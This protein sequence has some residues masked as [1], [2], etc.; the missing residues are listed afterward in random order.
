MPVQ[1]VPTVGAVQEFYRTNTLNE[2]QSDVTYALNDA[3]VYEGI[4][5]RSVQNSNLNNS[6][7]VGGEVNETWWEIVGGGKGSTIIEN[8]SN[9]SISLHNVIALSDDGYAIIADKQ[10]LSK[11]RVLGIAVEDYTINTSYVNSSGVINEESYTSPSLPALVLPFHTKE[12]YIRIG[13]NNY[14]LTS[15][16]VDSISPYSETRNTDFLDVGSEVIDFELT[17]DDK[18]LIIKVSDNTVRIYNE[19][20]EGSGIYDNFTDSLSIIPD[21]ILVSDYANDFVIIRG[22]RLFSYYTINSDGT[23]TQIGSEINIDTDTGGFDPYDDTVYIDEFQRV[24]FHGTDGGSTPYQ[25]FIYEYHNGSWTN[26]FSYYD[27]NFTLPTEWT[28]INSELVFGYLGEGK[29]G[30]YDRI[31]EDFYLYNYDATN[32]TFSLLSSLSNISSFFAH[33]FKY[34]RFSEKRNL[35]VARDKI[36]SVDGDTLRVTENFNSEIDGFLRSVGFSNEFLY[37]MEEP[38]EDNYTI[39]LYKDTTSGLEIQKIGQLAD[40]YTLATITPGSDLFLGN[41][42][43]IITDTNDIAEGEARVFLGTMGRNNIIDLLIMEPDIND[44]D[45]ATKDGVPVGGI[46]PLING[47]LP[48]DGYVEI[49]AGTQLAVADYPTLAA[50]HPD[51]LDGTGTLI[52]IPDPNEGIRRTDFPSNP[53]IGWEVW[54]TDLEAWFKYNGEFWLEI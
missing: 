43:A 24:F 19:T 22:V 48:A 13:T 37:V 34:N 47:Q 26:R 31:N 45:P 36:I 54:R 50:L 9:Q 49:E 29:V 23:L 42:G 1:N 44:Y 39:T 46:L 16:L 40:P 27:T 18:F 7:V 4:P 3:I 25:P 14:R 53:D 30:L 15:V 32:F 51:W 35:F 12:G 10:D 28:T 5:Y 33:I 21:L 52:I 17:K 2:W 20:T 38:T 41:S 8:Q 6:P 11:S